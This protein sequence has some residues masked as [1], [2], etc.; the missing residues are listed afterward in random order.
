MGTLGVAAVDA[1]SGDVAVVIKIAL[2]ARAAAAIVDLVLR[3]IDLNL[4]QAAQIAR[5]K[6]Q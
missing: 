4:I 1:V 2:Y 5:R 3:A 6:F